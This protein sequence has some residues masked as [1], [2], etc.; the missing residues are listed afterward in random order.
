MDSSL[1]HSWYCAR[2]DC[3]GG[4][5]IAGRD[6]HH[7]QRC[8]GAALATVVG[9]LIEVPLMLALVG[10]CKRTQH[11]FSQPD[12]AVNQGTISGVESLKKF[13]SDR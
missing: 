9:V 1:Y 6:E 12:S 2:R 11:W 10:F 3:A 8:S 7:S 5:E 13:V 4:C